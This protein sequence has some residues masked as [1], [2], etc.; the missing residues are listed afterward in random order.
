MVFVDMDGVLAR[1]DTTASLEDTYKDGY[2]S[3]REEEPKIKELI[4]T[5]IACGHK[6]AILSAVYPTG[7][8]AADKDGWLD[9]HGL[10]D[11]RRIFV[12]YGKDKHDYIPKLDEPM[13]LLDD[14]SQN[15]HTWE[16]AGH[17]G[18]KFL[19]GI[20]GTHGTWKGCSID[21]GMKVEEMYAIIASEEWRRKNE[22]K[23][24]QHET[25]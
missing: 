10:P 24:V 4:R 2:F 21:R 23:R 18:V 13:V 22:N 1:W 6:V 12:P 11:V 19:N 14:F 25:Q 16:Q 20:N 17:I 7:T 8:A 15:L 5:L 9:E 3:K